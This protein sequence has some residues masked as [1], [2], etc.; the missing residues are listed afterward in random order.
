MLETA[1]CEPSWKERRQK[2]DPGR[3]LGHLLLMRRDHGQSGCVLTPEVVGNGDCQARYPWPQGL[4]P[5]C[6]KTTQRRNKNS[7]DQEP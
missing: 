1:L 4:Q 5:D 3:A 2:G 6:G 7:L